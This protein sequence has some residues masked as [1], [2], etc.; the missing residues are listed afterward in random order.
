MSELKIDLARQQERLCTAFEAA[1]QAGQRPDMNDFLDQIDPSGHDELAREL[2]LLDLTY[3][4]QAGETPDLQAYADRFPG[5]DLDAL[6]DSIVT[7]DS[8]TTGAGSAPTAPPELAGQMIGHYRIDEPLGAGGMGAV[9]RAHDTAL[10]RDVALKL[11]P[12][13][14]ADSLRD[15]LLREAWA[16]AKLQHPC[17]ATFYEAG[18]ADGHCFIAMERVPGQ[19]LRQRLRSG[20][21][22]ADQALTLTAG[23]LEA[24]V[25][26]HAADILHRDIKPENLMV[27]PDGKPKLLDFGLAKPV[28]VEEPSPLAARGA[29]GTTQGGSGEDG[30]PDQ[31]VDY[32]AANLAR[33]AGEEFFGST[34]P[35]T[36]TGVVVGTLGYLSPEQLRGDPVDARTDLFAVGVVLYELLTGERAFPGKLAADRI[37]ALLS[38][39]PVNLGDDAIPDRLRPVL[40]RA[41]A[42]DV[43][44]RYASAR[45]LLRDL[46]QVAATEVA[47]GLSY[48][49]AILP[50]YDENAAEKDGWIGASLTQ[51][52]VASLATI[53]GLSLVPLAKVAAAQR[54]LPQ[55]DLI[56]GAFLGC[57]WLVKGWYRRQGDRLT[58]QLGALEVATGQEQTLGQWEVERTQLAELPGQLADAVGTMLGSEARAANTSRTK[59]DPR[60][61]QLYLQAQQLFAKQ[62]PSKH[63]LETASELLE[64]AI[65]LEPNYA[66]ALA[67][68]TQYYAM[69]HLYVPGTHWLEQALELGH[70]ATAADPDLAD[71]HLWL[72]YAVS[73]KVYDIV[74]SGRPDAARPFFEQMSQS[75]QRAYTLDPNN[76]FTGYFFAGTYVLKACLYLTTA[77]E[78]QAA[79]REALRLL[80]HALKVNPNYGFGW[81]FI[82]FVHLDLGATREARWCL[83]KAVEL[84]PTN[85]LPTAGVAVFLGECLRRCGKLAA[86][87]DQ[88]LRGLEATQKTDHMYRDSFRGVGLCVLG[89]TTLE[90][91]DHDAARSAFRQVIQ[92]VHGRPGFRLSGQLLVQAHAGLS[93]LN[94]DEQAFAEA[95]RLFSERPEPLEFGWLW[96]GWDEITLLELARAAH[97]LGNREQAAD[98]LGQARRR[99]SVEAQAETFA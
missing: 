10:D 46:R 30:P 8:Q 27:T 95:M 3:R 21:V 60:A 63:T 29:A 48:S 38:P 71:G 78:Q 90:Q 20:P 41:L 54:S 82:G 67:A 7:K 5:L 43:Q 64:Q 2:V 33:L 96:W 84:E 98:L 66:A 53:P 18:D 4:R 19:T 24:L 51:G 99:G 86:A 76:P 12:A 31:T 85:R 17:I 42:K 16:S 37:R 55:A 58:V 73:Q 22:P 91:A 34:G 59:L 15:R 62:G 25:H 68:L 88:C 61:H 9:Y 93:R 97:H 44:D 70:R 52:L 14:F 56:L 35:L 89:R 74:A 75:Q 81:L 6:A 1:W 36:Q 39:E 40:A 94:Q 50:F 83:E 77:Q 72:G 65:A 45:D 79:R 49:L 13:H 47:A 69:R 28:L 11:L 92:L 26:A 32:V 80:Q 57:H 23:V 87:R